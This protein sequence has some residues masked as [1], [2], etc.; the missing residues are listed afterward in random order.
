MKLFISGGTKMVLCSKVHF[1]TQV[2]LLYVC[3]DILPFKLLKGI[4]ILVYL[5]FSFRGKLQIKI[6]HLAN[7]SKF[8]NPN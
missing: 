8:L 3:L 4:L 6:P 5:H 2:L 7:K 1:Q